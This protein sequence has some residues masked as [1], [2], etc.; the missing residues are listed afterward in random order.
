[1]HNVVMQDGK[2]MITFL[3]SAIRFYVKSSDIYS[4]MLGERHYNI[5]QDIKNLGLTEDYKAS[6]I[7]GFL[8][9]VT[10]K[11]DSI[12]TFI[13]REN[14]TEIAKRANYPMIGSVLTSEDLW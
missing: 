5:I 9:K 10:T 13:S 7:D 14:A 2:R 6:H 11:K 3:Q 1:M 8:C 12:I 4:T